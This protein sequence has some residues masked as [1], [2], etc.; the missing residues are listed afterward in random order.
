MS[1][2]SDVESRYGTWEMCTTRPEASTKTVVGTALGG[3]GKSGVKLDGEDD[4]QPT[5]MTSS[6][7]RYD[8]RITVRPQPPPA[9]SP[10]LRRLS[11][12]SGRCRTTGTT[13]RPGMHRTP[14]CARDTRAGR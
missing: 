4:E 7:N 11:D 12:P 14:A 8:R 3:F 6:T 2:R 10:A 5:A 1:A 9:T 13:A